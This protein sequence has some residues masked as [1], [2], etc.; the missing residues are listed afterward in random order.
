[1]RNNEIS[2]STFHPC[3]MV[4]VFSNFHILYSVKTN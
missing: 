4:D 3:V 1:M 2:E